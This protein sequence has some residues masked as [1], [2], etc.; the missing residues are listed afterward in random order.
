MFSTVIRHSCRLDAGGAVD[1]AGSGQPRICSA[2]ICLFCD[3]IV[4]ND[5]IHI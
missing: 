5:G 3:K 4:C 2:E 1:T